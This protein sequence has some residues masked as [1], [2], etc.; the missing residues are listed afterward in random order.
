MHSE[1]KQRLFIKRLK[2]DR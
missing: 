1:I 2:T